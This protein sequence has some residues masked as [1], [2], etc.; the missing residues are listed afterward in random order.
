MDKII[1]KLIKDIRKEDVALFIGSGFSLKAGAPSASDIIKAIVSEASSSF[2][3]NIP[4]KEQTLRNISEAYIKECGGK[5]E[6]MCILRKLF[7]FEPKD[8]SDQKMLYN[9]P[10]FKTIFT[11]NYDTLIEDAYPRSECVVVTTNKGATYTK[12]NLPTIYKIHGDITTLNDPDSIIISESNYRNLFISKDFEAIT[13]ELKHT[14]MNKHVLFIGYS[15]ADDDVLELIKTV[16]DCVGDNMKGMYLVAPSMN[17]RERRRL[18]KNK[19]AYINASAEDVLNTILTELKA[20]VTKDYRKKIVSQETYERFC[21]RNGGLTTTTQHLENE[22]RIEKIHIIEGYKKTEKL[23]ITVNSKTIEKIK[24]N[25][26]NDVLL[27]GSYLSVPAYKITSSSILDL[28][29]SLN[30]ITFLTKEDVSLVTITPQTKKI[31]VNVNMDEI[32]FSETLKAILYKEGETT[33][34]DF[35]TPICTMKMSFFKNKNASGRGK[36]KID[37]ECIENY[38]S[39]NDAFKWILFILNMAEGKECFIYGIKLGGLKSTQEVLMELKKRKA[40]YESIKNIEKKLDTTFSTYDKFS[41]KNAEKAMYIYSYLFQQYVEIK[42]PQSETI[43]FEVDTREDINKPID[44]FR[45]TNFG[46]VQCN[47]IGDITLNGRSFNVP[48]RWLIFK[49]CLAKDIKQLNEYQYRITA[50]ELSQQ[51]IIWC[52]REEFKKETLNIK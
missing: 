51:R 6:L 16:R 20:N 26:Y 12:D 9:I 5:N 52:T 31:N 18:E 19:V 7:S 37:I 40:Y 3:D 38:K 39:I 48:Y 32:N 8:T 24:G 2:L 1:E 34:I 44:K 41:E 50:Q 11:T 17:N 25:E 42:A 10:H 21:S 23:K 33:H 46:M 15:L 35:E 30:G 49:N 29:Y 45:N 43:T 27:W 36:L 4:Q 22:N 47:T 28:S 14:F 13:G